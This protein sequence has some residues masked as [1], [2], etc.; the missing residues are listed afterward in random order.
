M[1]DNEK[2]GSEKFDELNNSSSQDF[3]DN[4]EYL[5]EIEKSVEKNTVEKN[6]FMLEKN[7]FAL[8]ALNFSENFDKKI[9]QLIEKKSR[10][11]SEVRNDSN[12]VDSQLQSDKRSLY[13]E[14]Y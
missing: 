6:K 10:L 14:D 9:N 13:D 5:D 1:Q 11:S 12:E 7:M 8:N 2:Q 4:K 3:S